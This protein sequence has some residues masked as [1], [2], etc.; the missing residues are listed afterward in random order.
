LYP[1]NDGT[2]RPLTVILPPG[3]VVSAVKPAAMRQ[4]MTIPMTVVDTIFKALSPAIPERVIA[5]HHADLCSTNLFGNDPRTGRFYVQSIGLPGGGWGGKRDSDGMS[6]TVCINDGDTHNSPTEATE[7]KLPLLIERY[8]LRTDSGGAGRHRGGLGVERR[9]RALA[10]MNAHTRM[11]R[12]RCAPWGLSGGR[13]GLPNAV[14][15]ERADGSI[16]QPP[17]GKLPATLLSPGD[18][19]V[20]ESGGGGGFGDPR[21]RSH[22][23][24]RNDVRSGYVTGEVALRDYGLTP[25]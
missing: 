25:E 20:T 18:V 17:N 12:T 7:A 15:I 6:A 11:E 9:M 16:L 24:V 22:D 13:D 4:W 21:E 8:A 19:L 23:A 2:F 5:G 14:R 10:P 1:I 3:R